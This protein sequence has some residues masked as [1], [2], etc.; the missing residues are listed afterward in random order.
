[1]SWVYEGIECYVR[2]SEASGYV[3]LYR[4]W[5]GR[6]HFYTSSKSEYDGL[7]QGYHR[8]GIACYVALRPGPLLV[9]LYRLYKGGADDHFYCISKTERDKAIAT[10]GYTDE[11]IVGYVMPTEAINFVALYR[12]W[13]PE[14]ADHFYT[15][16]VKEIDDNGPT[17]SNNEMRDLLQ[18]KMKDYL[19]SAKIYL[20]DRDY[21]CP[22]EKVA[23]DIID[24]CRVDQRQYI[25]EIHDC[26]DFAHLLKAAFIEDAYDGGRR[27]MPYS[28]GV[29]WGSTPSHAMNV[30]VVGDGASY[31]VKLVEP[32]TGKIHA[33]SSN[34]LK[35]I[36][37]VVM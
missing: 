20:A 3:P 14:I 13:N 26:D 15:A 19:A 11:G 23:G 7:P 29:V 37:L 18:D 17:R 31:H 32:Q 22:T 1:M 30:L 5:N 12:A 6:D 10:H 33:L 34:K 27:S 36:Y 21:F 24:A 25:S 9:A 8:E 4:A 2:P 16:T 35:G 28:L